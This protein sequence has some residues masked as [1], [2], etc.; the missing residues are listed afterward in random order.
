MTTRDTN[1]DL[2]ILTGV[3]KAASRRSMDY[4]HCPICRTPLPIPNPPLCPKRNCHMK[5][6]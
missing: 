6:S 3:M 5:F 2:N 1:H 4:A